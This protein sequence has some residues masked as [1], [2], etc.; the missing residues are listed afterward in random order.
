MNPYFFL[1]YISTFDLLLNGTY[2]PRMLQRHF[3]VN[4]GLFLFHLYLQQTL[5]LY[6]IKITA[7]SQQSSP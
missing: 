2:N 3:K 4:L 7:S 6:V 1:F 5:F